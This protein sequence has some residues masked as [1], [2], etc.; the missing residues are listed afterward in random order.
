[1]EYKCDWYGK[2]FI[3]IGQYEPSSKLCSCGIIN[4]NLTLK[5]RFWTCSVC[6]ITHD[7]DILAANNIKQIGL[8]QS[9][10]TPAE[11]CNSD[12]LKQEITKSKG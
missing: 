8:V 6:N 3:K 9:E 4:Q 5:D 1:L 11:S 10:F 7:R 12:S 2:N